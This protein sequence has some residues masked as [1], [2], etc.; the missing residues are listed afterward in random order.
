MKRA[1][2]SDEKKDLNALLSAASDLRLYAAPIANPSGPLARA[3]EGNGGGSGGAGGSVE[4]AGGTDGNEKPGTADDEQV[5]ENGREG[6]GDDSPGEEEENK[7]V[8]DMTPPTVL[9]G[10]ISISDGCGGVNPPTTST[11]DPNTGIVTGNAWGLGMDMNP[12][13]GPPS[14]LGSGVGSHLDALGNNQWGAG[15]GGEMQ[16]VPGMLHASGLQPPHNANNGLGETDGMSSGWTGS[17]QLP[18]SVANGSVAGGGA[19]ERQEGMVDHTGYGASTGGETGFLEWGDKSGLGLG[20]LQPDF[21][22]EGDIFPAYRLMG[23][24]PPPISPKG[25]DY[26]LPPP[27]PDSP[28]AAEK[29]PEPEMQ[30]ETVLT[31]AGKRKAIEEG[32]VS[33]TVGK[34]VRKGNIPGEVREWI[35]KHS[36]YLISGLEDA[37]EWIELV[38]MW[39][40]FEE[41]QA[42]FHGSGARFRAG[43][44][45]AAL[46][47]WA[48]SLTPGSFEPVVMP[49]QQF[50][51]EWVDW[52]NDVQPDWRKGFSGNLPNRLGAVNV[53]LLQLKKPGPS[54]LV[55]FLMSL[56]WWSN[57]RSVDGRWAMA[58]AD[59]AD[60]LGRLAA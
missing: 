42:R 58:V 46:A 27:P 36:A 38:K 5:E 19:G 29:S 13:W 31:N 55:I 24:N 16:D 32:E 4:M 12:T 26:R 14:S 41:G 17:G 44:R 9:W 40:Q 47:K 51:N 50:A 48:S 28:Q 23:A 37:A 2:T 6:Q 21:E 56:K 10:G 20:L 57:L 39:G 3:P 1:L 18:M 34:R 49:D 43:K 30:P 7:G 22:S 53:N 8:G 60:C 25:S 59:L 11:G 33:I 45:P 54:G 15:A 52:W 35:L